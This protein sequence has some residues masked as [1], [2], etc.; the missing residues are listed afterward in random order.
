MYEEI[1]LSLPSNAIL[2]TSNGAPRMKLRESN[3]IESNNESQINEG[4]RAETDIY[5]IGKQPH[6][7]TDY[8][9]TNL[10]RER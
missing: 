6:V 2:L 5:F 8:E 7:P 1:P 3:V 4:K 9:S 10:K